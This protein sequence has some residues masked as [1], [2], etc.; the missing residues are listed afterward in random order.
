MNNR[1]AL[2]LTILF[3][4]LLP[5][6]GKGQELFNRRFHL[7]YQSLIFRSIEV[8]KDGYWIS[9]IARDTILGSFFG[10][11]DFDGQPLETH[12][13]KVGYYE[14]IQTWGK[15]LHRIG[16]DKWIV[17]GGGA[18]TL[19]SYA[20]IVI[21]NSAG[22]TLQVKRIYNPFF[23]TVSF[24]NYRPGVMPY[25][26]GYVL[27]ASIENPDPYPGSDLYVVKLNEDLEVEWEKLLV[28]E[29]RSNPALSLAE[30]G[31]NIMLGAWRTNYSFVNDHYLSQVHLVEL[32][33]TGTK[34]DGRW[35]PPP[36]LEDEVL[37]GPADALVVEEDGSVVVA[38]REGKEIPLN[39]NF[40]EIIWK[41]VI[42]KFDAELGDVLWIRPMQSGELSISNQF[43]KMVKVSDGSGYVAAGNG[44]LEL[45]QRA[46]S[47]AKVSVAGDSLWLRH[48]Q[49]VTTLGNYHYLYD[50]EE[51]SDG[52]FIMVGEA[53][54]YSGADSLFPPPIQQGW[55]LKVDEHG[56]LVPGCHLLDA[57]GE[58]ADRSPLLRLYP[59]PAGDYLHVYFRHPQA[60]SGGHFRLINVQGLEL[61][62]W[63]ATASDTT[64]ILYLDDC[65]PGLYFLQYWERGRLVRV[66]KVVVE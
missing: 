49:Y 17:S 12:V 8:E 34:V 10:R 54:P 33:S 42:L 61:R 43:Y 4:L 47:I 26:G 13:L 35:Y 50:L 7:G 21:Y 28:E 24:I 1:N 39:P 59:N 40:S 56:C 44:L 62:S 27:F 30:K 9:G 51:T 19:G 37:M 3:L 45:G 53:R 11:F 55:L 32:D 63:P 15:D 66:E 18:D 64:Y 22:D 48:Y 57:V 52:G 41:K 36:V 2:S 46:G 60:P 31:D 5:C 6:L 29:E 16:P 23:P 25:K 65:A 14:T 38:T 20:L 58:V